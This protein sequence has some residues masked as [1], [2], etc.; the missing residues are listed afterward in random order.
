MSGDVKRSVHAEPIRTGFL[1]DP[2]DNE[3]VRM[4]DEIHPLPAA[5]PYKSPSTVTGDELKAL[6]RDVAEI[7]TLLKAFD[8]YLSEMTGIRLGCGDLQ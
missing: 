8:V 7:K 2:D 6:A 3:R 4:V 1:E 5:A